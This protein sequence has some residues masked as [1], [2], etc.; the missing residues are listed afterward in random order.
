MRYSLLEIEDAATA[1]DELTKE[2]KDP[3]NYYFLYSGDLL[4]PNKLW[5]KSKGTPPSK[6][7]SGLPDEPGL[8]SC[9]IIDLAEVPVLR[10]WL[11]KGPCGTLQVQQH[12]FSV[13]FSAAKALKA[14]QVFAQEKGLRV[15]S[16]KVGQ[17][18]DAE[19]S[20]PRVTARLMKGDI[21]ITVICAVDMIVQCVNGHTHDLLTELESGAPLTAD[22]TY[23]DREGRTQKDIGFKIPWGTDFITIN[24]GSGWRSLINRA[25]EGKA[26]YGFPGTAQEFLDAALG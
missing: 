17:N 23:V 13:V 12:H 10:Q 2:G 15:A 25:K 19:W 21:Q 8:Y 3:S 14:I 6:I 26:P 7:P 16:H 18:I 1:F 9:T 11:P 20:P 5:D 4:T 22:H 24:R